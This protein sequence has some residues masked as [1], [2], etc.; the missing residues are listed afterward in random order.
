MEIAE[1]VYVLTERNDVRAS[2]AEKALVAYSRAKGEGRNIDCDTA[3]DLMQ[4]IMHWEARRRGEDVYGVAV[5][6]EPKPGPVDYEQVRD[7]VQEWFMSA[8]NDFPNEA[9][10]EIGDCVDCGTP[11]YADSDGGSVLCPKCD[12]GDS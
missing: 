11:C 8:Y 4:D 5:G 6:E 12:K 2:A 1:S 10:G 3:R 7:A 9:D